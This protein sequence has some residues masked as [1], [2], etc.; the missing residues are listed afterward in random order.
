MLNTPHTLAVSAQG[1]QLN[2]RVD[3]SDKGTW[4]DT[5]LP[6]TNGAVGIAV[7]GGAKATFSEV[8]AE[9]A[10]WINQPPPARRL[11]RGRLR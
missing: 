10:P 5:F 4:H 6:L 8:I 1:A 11:A 9:Q 3:G 7:S 2:M